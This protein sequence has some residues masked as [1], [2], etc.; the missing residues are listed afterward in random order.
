MLPGPSQAAGKEDAM[1][2]RDSLGFTLIEIM[3]VVII[4]GILA[5]MIVP[6]LSGRGQQARIAAAQADI[7]AN[8][9]T[10][11]NLYEMDN[12]Q[13]PSSEQG[14]KALIQEPTSFPAPPHW[15]GPYLKRKKLPRDPWGKVYLYVSPGVHNPQDYD[16]SS[17]GPDG[18][19]SGDDIVNWDED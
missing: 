18:L 13:Y 2:V 8:L 3:M 17:L 14:L 6:N 1:R 5:A 11:L 7:D 9:A 19:E 10:A 16:L 4:L 12:A 15:N